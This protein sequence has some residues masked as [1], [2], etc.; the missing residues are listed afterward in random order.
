MAKRKIKVYEP[1]GFGDVSKP[2]TVEAELIR[3]LEDSNAPRMD[4]YR[5][6]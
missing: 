3:R 2:V 5:S 6:L 1:I 4:Q